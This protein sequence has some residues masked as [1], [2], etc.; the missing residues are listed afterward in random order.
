MFGVAKTLVLRT[1]SRNLISSD[2]RRS[3]VFCP[4]RRTYTFLHHNQSSKRSLVSRFELDKCPVHSSITPNHKFSANAFGEQSSERLVL[5]S[6][7]ILKS[8]LTFGS[9]KYSSAMA[10]VYADIAS[11]ADIFGI[12]EYCGL[13]DRLTSWV[14]LIF[15]HVWIYNVALSRFDNSAGCKK[16]LIKNMWLDVENRRRLLKCADFWRKKDL[17]NFNKTFR[18]FYFQMDLAY[19]TSDAELA[20]AVYKWILNN[21]FREN[22]DS[23]QPATSFEQTSAAVDFLVHYVRYHTHYLHNLTNDQLL[24]QSGEK[25]KVKCVGWKPVSF[26]VDQN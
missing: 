11:N 24:L 4:S 26:F 2:I 16:F 10:E 5:K 15:L 18:N 17:Q 25:E 7:S 3:A 20:A 6:D 12:W 19:L 13:P 14:Y 21:E 1:S 22:S 23:I 8:I 9:H